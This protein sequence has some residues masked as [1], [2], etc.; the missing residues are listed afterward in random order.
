MT[1]AQFDAVQLL[2]G[3]M[4]KDRRDA[5]R[6]ALVD[7]QTQQLIAAIYGW[8]RTAVDNAERAIWEAFGRYEEAKQ[9]EANGGAKLPRGWI[10]ISVAAPRE[11][12]KKIEAEVAALESERG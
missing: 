1:A 6:M 7:G 2:I 8:G 4:S 11:V 10:R 12:A 9:V 5:A 3:T